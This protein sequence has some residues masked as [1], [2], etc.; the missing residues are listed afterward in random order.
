M[1]TVQTMTN[2]GVEGDQWELMLIGNTE[3]WKTYMQAAL[4]CGWY[5]AKCSSE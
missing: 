5:L 4:D 1:L 2:W 3:D